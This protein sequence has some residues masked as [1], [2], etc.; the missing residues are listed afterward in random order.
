MDEM[1]T[2]M[3]PGSNLSIACP[4]AEHRTAHID[5]VDPVP[6]L[7]RDRV[8]PGLS[9]GADIEHHPVEAAHGAMRLLD[10]ARDIALPGDI[11]DTVKPRP[12]SVVIWLTV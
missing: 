7:G 9:E 1:K 8:E 6:F 3:P 11:G 4:A 12:P 2:M 10:H 5:V